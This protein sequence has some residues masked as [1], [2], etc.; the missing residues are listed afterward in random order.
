MNPAVKIRT[1][2]VP[3]RFG[4][5]AGKARVH[6]RAPARGFSP[7]HFQVA[8]LWETRGGE[9]DPEVLAALE[10]GSGDQGGYSAPDRLIDSSIPSERQRS[11]SR[12]SLV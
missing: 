11:R 10:D 6:L 12:A 5:E 4:D 8:W 9:I 2:V 7:V 1:L 3:C